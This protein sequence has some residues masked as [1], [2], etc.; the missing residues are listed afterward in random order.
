MRQ[1]TFTENDSTP[2]FIV[3][4]DKDIHVT[5]KGSFG[6][7]TITL[8]HKLQ[9]DTET[10]VDP[11]GADITHTDNFDRLTA[12]RRHEVVRLTLTGSTTPSIKWA[13]YGNVY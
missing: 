12:F 13:F 11:D 9:G 2:W 4:G 7:G 5:G 3:W 8:E 10:L 1:G 6:G